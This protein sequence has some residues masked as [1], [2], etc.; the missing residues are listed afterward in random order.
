MKMAAFEVTERNTLRLVSSTYTFHAIVA[1]P[2]VLVRLHANAQADDGTA[3]F[4][5]LRAALL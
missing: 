1:L 2:I 5:A 4:V 3:V